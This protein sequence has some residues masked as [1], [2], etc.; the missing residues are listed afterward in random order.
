MADPSGAALSGAGH[1]WASLA[2]YTGGGATGLAFDEEGGLL[3]TA[4]IFGGP[5]QLRRYGVGADG[6]ALDCELMATSAARL[7]TVRVADGLAYV[8][9]P[10]GIYT[11]AVPEPAL[12]ALLLAGWMVCLRRRA[13]GPLKKCSPAASAG[14]GAQ[15][16]SLWQRF[17]ARGRACHMLE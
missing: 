3:V 4:T 5:S 10:A 15:A 2:G 14:C 12:L 6:S 7:T 13:M 1:L 17:H 8:A 16:T 9:S 11:V